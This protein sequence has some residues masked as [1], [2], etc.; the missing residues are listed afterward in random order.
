MRLVLER[1]GWRIIA[2][3]VRVHRDEIDLVAIDP[4]PPAALVCVEVRSRSGPRFGTPEE[5][6]DDRK[7]LRAYRAALALAAAG[8]LPD[9]LPLPR[10]PMRVDLVSVETGGTAASGRAPTLRHLRGITPAHR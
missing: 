10:V 3:N 8:R 2:R 4:G 5:S 7:V 9:G 6:V 1:Q